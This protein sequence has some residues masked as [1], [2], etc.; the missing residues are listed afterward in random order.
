MLNRLRGSADRQVG[1]GSRS[2]GRAG[3]GGEGEAGLERLPDDNN[4]VMQNP[5]DGKP[6]MF[7]R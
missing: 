3:Q 6:E 1:S 7:I 5:G 2:S 4:A